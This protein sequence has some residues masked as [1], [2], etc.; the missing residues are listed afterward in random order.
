MTIKIIIS[1]R[2]IVIVFNFQTSFLFKKYKVDVCQ[3]W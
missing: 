2:K 1:D 3:A